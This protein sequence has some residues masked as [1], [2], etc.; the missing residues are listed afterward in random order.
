MNIKRFSKNDW[1]QYG[2]AERFKDGSEPFIFSTERNG[3]CID[4][5]GDARGVELNIYGNR[6]QDDYEDEEMI[7]TEDIKTTPKKMRA[8]LK[9][10]IKAY[11]LDGDWYAPDISYN[12]DHGYKLLKI[13]EK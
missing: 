9:N 8:I 1:Y 13:Q 5:I 4:L 2:G 10:I 3:V 6:D 12:L 7:W 11:N